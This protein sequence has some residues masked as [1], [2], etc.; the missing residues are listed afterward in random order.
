MTTLFLDFETRNTA[1]IKVGTHRYA[2]TA[3]VLLAAYSHGDNPVRVWDRLECPDMPDGL[4]DA[5]EDP[6]TTIVAHN[7]AFDRTILRVVL[8]VFT[9]ASRWHC[10]MAQALAHSLPASLGELCK[11]YKLPQDDA[12]DK[13][14]R[15][16]I[17]LFCKPNRKGTFNDATTHPVEWAEFVEY[18]RKDVVS[19][20]ILRGKMPVRNYLGFE[21]ESWVLDQKI[22]D[23]GMHVDLALARGAVEA[24]KRAQAG[25][26]A[27]VS[28]DTLGMVDSGAKRAQL[29]AYIK[30]TFGVDMPDMTKA[31]VQG[32]I[33]ADDTPED[34]RELL[35]ARLQS[36]ASSTA[37][38]ESLLK[39]VSWDGRLRGTKQWC[40]ASRTGRW[41]GRI[42]QPDNLPRPDMK[43]PQIDEGVRAI[44][45][46][47]ADMITDNVM[48]LASN[49]IRACISA[50]PAKK[51]VVADLSNIEGRVAAW[52]AG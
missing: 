37:K 51:L 16:L 34:M 21:R 44:K 10:T 35:V 46:G 28:A 38:F 49:T 36:S 23:R 30:A 17:Q 1:D 25:L 11:I 29:Q 31:T 8:G 15:R 2:E 45:A 22:N 3:Q 14:G 52:L 20:R 27:Q 48:K 7:A 26:A 9:K 19:M 50:P 33:D 18:A 40:G 24:V 13:R 4:R 47:C 32:Y 42:F 5:L 39:A 43:Q 41:A 12:K 6:E